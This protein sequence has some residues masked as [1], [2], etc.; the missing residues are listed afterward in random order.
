M[1]AEL[2]EQLTNA[3]T[4]AGRALELVA[5]LALSSGKGLQ[6]ADAIRQIAGQLD[7]AQGAVDEYYDPR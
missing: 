7:E 4:R 2:Y 5:H 3:T 6:F 1:T